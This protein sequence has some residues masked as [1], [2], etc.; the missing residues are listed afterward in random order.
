VAQYANRILALLTSEER[1]LLEPHLER[2]SIQPREVLQQAGTVI[3]H[4][5]FPESGMIS[6]VLPLADGRVVEV[7]A[8]GIEG[9][10]G[11]TLATNGGVA[12]PVQVVG[13]VGGE[14]IRIS[15]GPFVELLPQCPGLSYQARRFATLML[16]V[17]A[18]NVACG[19]MH[20]IGERLA[21]WLLTVKDLTNSS[22]FNL[23]QE[24]MAEMLGTN[25]PTVTLA[26]LTLANAG[27]IRYARGRI[28]ILDEQGLEDSACECYRSLRVE[29]DGLSA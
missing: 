8:I 18:Q 22:R 4:A 12:G 1:S 24:F 21:R 17:T 10:A 13:Q 20:Q 27:L 6:L 15:R 9:M 26:A 5:Y 7:G 16:A 19:Q 3:S 25:R 11:F 2:V 14:A 29:Y 28:E 23:T